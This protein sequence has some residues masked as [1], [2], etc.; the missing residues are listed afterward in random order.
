MEY[1]F[2]HQAVDSGHFV[3]TEDLREILQNKAHYAWN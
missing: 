1:L 2:C 3:T